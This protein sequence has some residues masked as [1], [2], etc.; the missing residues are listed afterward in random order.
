MFWQS[1]VSSCCTCVYVS[2][3]K[4]LLCMCRMAGGGREKTLQNYFSKMSVGSTNHSVTQLASYLWAPTHMVR[5]RG[6]RILVMCFYSHR[7]QACSLPPWLVLKA[8][9]NMALGW[10]LA[11]VG[12]IASLALHLFSVQATP[13]LFLS[14]CLGDLVYKLWSSATTACHMEWSCTRVA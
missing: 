12:W 13:C 6:G 7:T 2:C 11:A 4:L 9:E 8:V 5:R 3:P 10:H 1:K 14:S